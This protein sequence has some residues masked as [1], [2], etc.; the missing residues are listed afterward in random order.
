MAPSTKPD[1]RKKFL[2]A[3]NA[4][5][6]IERRR[7]SSRLQEHLFRHSIWQ[8]AEMVLSYAS[9]SSE[10]DTHS[11]IQEALRR[12]KT[13]AVPLYNPPG[14]ETALSKLVRFEDLELSPHF[15]LLE[16]RLDLRR[17][18]DPNAITLVLVPGIAFDRQGGRLGFGG[19]YF[20]RLLAGMPKA[21]KLGLAFS[22]QISDDPLPMGSHDI[23]MNAIVTEQGF[24]SIP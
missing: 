24:I 18:L 17:P 20:D 15:Q 12:Q 16:P 22:L 11:V 5:A 9:I 14:N 19:G 21:Y 2:A 13:L 10:V 23:R 4:L 8:A 1:L 7:M 6:A 3:R